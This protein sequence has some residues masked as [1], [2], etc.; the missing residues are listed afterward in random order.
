MLTLEKASVTSFLVLE[1]KKSRGWEISPHDNYPALLTEYAAQVPIKYLHTR[2]LTVSM[3]QH[4]E[5]YLT[6]SD[7]FPT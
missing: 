3:E 2:N 7:S 4:G 6:T 5:L 1:F